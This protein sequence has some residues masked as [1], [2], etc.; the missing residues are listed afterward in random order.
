MINIGKMFVNFRLAY[1][2]D[3]ANWENRFV[4]GGALEIL[5]CALLNSIGYKCRWIKEARYDIE[6]NGIK[7]S[8]KSNFTGTGDIIVDWEEPT[9]FFISDVGICYADPEMGLETRH[10]HDALVINTINT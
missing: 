6:I 7:F 1:D 9:L 2:Y 10:T 3:T 8:M 5:F 4:V